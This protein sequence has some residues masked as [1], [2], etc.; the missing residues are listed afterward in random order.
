MDT[1]H[2]LERP[3]PLHRASLVS[4]LCFCWLN[5]LFSVGR[6]RQLQGEDLYDAM[7]SDTSA[8]QGNEL[9]R[10]WDAELRRAKARGWSPSLT[11]ALWRCYWRRYALLGIF[12]LLEESVRVVQ[13]L[14]LGKLLNYFEGTLEGTAAVPPR[15]AAFLYAG[16]ISLCALSFAVTHH[17]YFLHV[18]LAGM[19]IRVAVCHM[20]YRKALRLSTA[21]MSRTTTGQIVN[22][23]SNDVNRYDQVTVFLHYLWSAPLQTAVVVVLLWQEVGVA[24]LAGVAVLALLMPMQSFIGSVFSRLRSKTARH[25]DSR[26]RTMNEVVSG[27]RIIK[28]YAWENPFALLVNSIR[29]LEVSKVLKASFLRGMNMAWFFMAGKL[30]LF[31]TFMTYTLMGH[32]ITAAR[33]F[34]AV[35]LYNA[36][37]LTVT[38]F[39]PSAIQA[40]SE[41]L[42]SNSR[43]QTFLMLDE[44][45][46]NTNQEEEEE[47]KE[48][49]GKEEEGKEEEEGENGPVVGDRT[50]F[51]TVENISCSWDKDSPDLRALDSISFTVGPGELVAIIGPVG[52]GKSS[53]LSALLG[54]L[55]CSL[56]RVRAR[57]RV[58]YACQQP[59]VFPDTVRQNILFGAAYERARYERVVRACSLR[60][61]FEMMSE[62]DLTLIGDRGVTLSGGQKARINLARAV[63]QDA[64]LYLLDDP[65]SAVDAEVG[66]ALFEKCIC[67]LLED[68]PRVLVTHQL[69]FLQEA[70]HIIVL[71]EGHVTARGTFSELLRSGVDF[72][73]LLRHDDHEE[74]DDIVP[75]DHRHGNSK[76]TL[77]SATS[78]SSIVSDSKEEGVPVDVMEEHR[79]Q[80]NVGFSVYKRYFRAGASIAML[81]LLLAVNVGATVL[82]VLQDWWLSYWATQQEVVMKW[83]ATGT[84]N[85]TAGPQPDPLDLSYYIGIYAGVTLGVVLLGM[86]RCLLFLKVLVTA[87][88]VLHNRMFSSVLRAPVYFYDVNPIGRVLNRFSKDIGQMDDLL[89]I[90]FLDFAQTSLQ[91]VGAMSVAVGVVPWVMIPVVPL[92]VVFF[93]LR[94]YYLLTARNIKR[95]EATARSPVFSHLSSS[96]QGLPVVR[97]FHVQRHFQST[98]DSLQDVHTEAWFLFLTTSRWLAVRLDL[99]CAVFVT[100]VSFSSI[101]ISSSLAAG[102]VGL[103]LSY[104]MSLTGMFQWGVRQS[105]EVE[106]YMTSVE[107]VLEYSELEPEAPWEAEKRPP[108]GWPSRGALCL[109][110]VSLRYPGSTRPVLYNLNA[111]IHPGEKIGIVGRTGAGKSSLLAALFRLAE[112]SGR[113]VIDGIATS[114]LGLHDLRRRISIIPQD[115][116]L[117]TGSMRK[118]LDPFGEH[119]DQDLWAALEEVQLRSVV[120]E[121]PARLDAELA[122]SGANLSVGQ[123]QL[124]CLARALLRH[125]N[126]LVIDEAT[127]NVD[128]RTDELIQKTIREKFRWCTVLTIAH[129]LHTIV[130]SDRIMVMEEGHIRELDS[131]HALLQDPDSLFLRLVQQT[132]RAEAIALT[133][134]ARQEQSKRELPPRPTNLVIMETAF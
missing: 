62:G 12:T 66:R 94:R 38:L 26:I 76:R 80:G 73:T 117:F 6:K 110:D 65:L 74:P 130:D 14:L 42:V 54:E 63:Y 21:A 103:A 83:N 112:P 52:A 37:R 46:K 89:P 105:A 87:S 71:K 90:T 115:P 77:S 22:L 10:Y 132:G 107:R 93:L 120:E 82:Y 96:L 15:L 123:R 43:I 7:P 23:L 127:A 114:S 111:T 30:I 128:P 106:S 97:A 2:K 125:N 49:E 56:G 4:R 18:Q 55:P 104:A 47:G 34:V 91:I 39:F 122:E 121:F 119:T 72:T 31:F 95:L 70:T 61:D 24:C 50:P 59:W 28:M 25:T 29:R 124:V 99:L 75:G 53:L 85:E 41:A 109:Q 88:R 81:L 79:A 67:G 16:G 98:F 51:I 32:P 44:I 17:L 36:V 92:L 9:Q 20:V 126:I 64:D 116:V 19:R 35:S 27:M 131:P 86:A 134:I 101:F 45:V 118:N 1:T 69:Q 13:P 58:A 68:K 3:N 78:D 102:Q 100:A 48:E 113:I 11:K 57:G 84:L 33:V 5:A 129:R 40:T 8:F 60:K 108:A 133:E